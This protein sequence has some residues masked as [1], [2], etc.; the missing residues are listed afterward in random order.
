MQRLR[1]DPGP[2]PAAQGA[3][4]PAVLV[5]WLLACH[6][7]GCSA[8]DVRPSLESDLTSRA[9]P[10]IVRLEPS[11]TPDTPDAAALVLRLDD[12]DAAVRVYAAEALR[13]ATGTLLGYRFY[14]NSRDR[15]AAVQRWQA[16]LDG[17]PLERLIA[18]A[19][20]EAPETSKETRS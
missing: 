2:T 9:V 5:A 8:P 19:A 4:S 1:V 7:P 16:W 12:D 10:A 11:L 18:E 3:R 17:A 15:R 13:R 14:R 20:A 6:A